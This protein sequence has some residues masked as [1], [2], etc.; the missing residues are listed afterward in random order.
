MNILE[1]IPNS[2][3]DF[4]KND[5]DTE[6]FLHISTHDTG[7]LVRIEPDGEY[8]YSFEDFEKMWHMADNTVAISGLKVLKII[9]LDPKKAT[10]KAIPLLKHT[11]RHY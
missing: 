9:S 5:S 4:Y 6:A 10:I 7:V 1:I 8:F 3:A 11:Q 2:P